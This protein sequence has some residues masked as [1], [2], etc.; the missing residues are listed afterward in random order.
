MSLHFSVSGDVLG[1]IQLSCTS[2]KLRCHTHHQSAE[3]KKTKI[4]SL[5][6][7]KIQSLM[8]REECMPMIVGHKEDSE[9][10]PA[11]TPHNTNR[12]GRR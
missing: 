4:Q 9:R 8:N 5:R 10:L 6:L 7:Q 3:G 2:Y 11:D 1:T 12:N